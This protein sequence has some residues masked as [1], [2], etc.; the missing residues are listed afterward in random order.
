MFIL[1]DLTLI[2]SDA[3]CSITHMSRLEQR[4]GASWLLNLKDDDLIGFLQEMM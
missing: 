1:T 4:D 2:D 3:V